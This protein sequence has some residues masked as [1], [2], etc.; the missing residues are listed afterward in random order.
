M[1]VNLINV[2]LNVFP[3]CN[4]VLR[5]WVS[6]RVGRR[7]T[8]FPWS[9]IPHFLFFLVLYF[10]LI[11]ATLIHFDKKHI[12]HKGYSASTSV[13][14]CVLLKYYHFSLTW[15]EHVFLLP[16]V[17]LGELTSINAYR[18]GRVLLCLAIIQVILY[19]NIDQKLRNKLHGQMYYKVGVACVSNDARYIICSNN[20]SIQSTYFKF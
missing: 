8:H 6:N 16:D 19:T 17:N 20:L 15:N 13:F 14:P 9:R 12:F 18:T 2:T 3:I 10:W 4:M 11:L 7:E 1:V 5:V